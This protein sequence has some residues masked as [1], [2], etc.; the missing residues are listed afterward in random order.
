MAVQGKYCTS[1]C[2]NS[3]STSDTYAA[4]SFGGGGCAGAIGA[5]GAGATT[6]AG[7]GVADGRGSI[8]E[9]EDRQESKVSM[10]QD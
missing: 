1:V 5:G 7:T 10:I 3:S 2:A 8:I 6:G 4:G 9:I